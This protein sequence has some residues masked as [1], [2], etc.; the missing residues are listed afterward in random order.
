MSPGQMV[1]LAPSADHHSDASLPALAIADAAF[2]GTRV[3]TVQ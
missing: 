1:V 3:L 2:Y